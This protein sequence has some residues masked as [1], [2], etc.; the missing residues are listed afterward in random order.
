MKSKIRLI[1]VALLVFV[2]CT[3]FDRVTKDYARETLQPSQPIT[4]WND[5]LRIQYTENPGA[6]LS[7]GADLP[8]KLRSLVFVLLVGI[9][10]A[11]L[12]VYALKARSLPP[13]QF[14]GLLLVLSGGIGN[15][16]DRLFNHG[17]AIDFLNLGIG[18][19][20]TG[21]FN[22]ADVFILVGGVLIVLASRNKETQASEA[23]VEKR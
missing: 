21:I 9:L 3:G 8:A 2:F 13:G 14:V 15:L 18:P 19:V 22:F 16:I 12:A 10:L 23:R 5:T 6:M 1:G 17:A 11:G 20:R 4:L 7:L